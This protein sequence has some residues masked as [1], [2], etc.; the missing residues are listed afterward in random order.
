MDDKTKMIDSVCN[1]D[2]WGRPVE[3]ILGDLGFDKSKHLTIEQVKAERIWSYCNIAW[4]SVPTRVVTII[5][6]S[7]N[8]LALTFWLLWAEVQ[9]SWRGPAA[10]GCQARLKA[11]V[12]LSLVAIT[13]KSTKDAL[14]SS[15]SVDT[16]PEYPCI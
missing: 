4:S 7:Q 3:K 15:A 8:Y 1:Y 9:K 16:L 14:D 10:S 12:C 11:H 5:P 13:T 6:P 2:R